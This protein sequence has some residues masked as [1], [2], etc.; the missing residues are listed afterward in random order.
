MSIK[1]KEVFPNWEVPEEIEL[2]QMPRDYQVSDTLDCLTW[3]V[4][5]N[6]SEVGTGKS[7]VAY[8]YIIKK[9]TEGNKVLVLM[10]PPLLYQFQREFKRIITGH[11]FRIETILKDKSK[12]EAWMQK[13]DFPEVLMMSYQLGVKYAR[14]LEEYT[15]LV[16]D[17]FHFASNVQTKAFSAIYYLFSRRCNSLLLM[18]ATPTQ[19]EIANAYSYVK[20]VSPRAYQNYEEFC[21]QHVEYGL[22][23]GTKIKQIVG[24][25]NIDDIERL[26]SIHTIRRRK[27]EVL[28]LDKPN[29]IQQ[30]V[31]MH[32]DHE[33]LYLRLMT[34]RM[35]EYS[36][37]QLLIARNKQA[38]RQLA[39]RLITN[40]GDFTQEL[41]PDHPLEMLRVIR[42]SIPGKLAVFCVFQDTVRKLAEKFADENPALIYGESDCQ[43]NVRR[44]QEDDNCT[45][46]IINYQSGGAGFN[47][48]HVCHNLVFY[49]TVGSPGQIEQAI[50]RVDRLGQTDV[51]NA[52]FFRYSM[53]M[54]DRLFS[55][56]KFRSL[57]IK[58]VLQDDT[59]FVDFLSS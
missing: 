6:F 19:T 39:L 36:P 56:A 53:T 10:P 42:N 33:E 31:Y 38:L 16:C 46:A 29:L 21:K 35:L 18:T 7:L 3:P 2:E 44:F 59:C 27:R 32:P 26:M 50:G 28:A 8:L 9:I 57:D 25:K 49:E 58:Q 22:M 23:P 41:I 54:S 48:Q 37:E 45:L 51:V 40:L 13:G 43:A 24:Y 52:W 14:D 4:A 15:V 47:L 12:R 5:K 11:N 20:L 55:K 30:F 1:L 34:E 17:E